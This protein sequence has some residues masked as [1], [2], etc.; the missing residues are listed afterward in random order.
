MAHA[1]A[2]GSITAIQ[3]KVSN[4]VSV[5]ANV[6]S[7]MNSAGT[8]AAVCPESLMNTCLI[9]PDRNKVS[10]CLVGKVEATRPWVVRVAIN[11]QRHFV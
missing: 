8:D 9:S 10:K 2:G 4:D 1:P 7:G 11:E 3:M 5:W 6:H